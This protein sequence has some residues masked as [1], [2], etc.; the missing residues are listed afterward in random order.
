MR[1]WLTTTTVLALLAVSLAAP[2]MAHPG[3]GAL[4]ASFQAGLTGGEAVFHSG[5]QAALRA[6]PGISPEGRIAPFGGTVEVCDTQVVGTWFFAFGPDKNA[7]DLYEVVSY[8]LN[9]AEI[10]LQQTATKPIAAGPD[11]GDWWFA[12]GDP[13]L[14]VLPPGSHEIGL[15]V[16]VVGFPLSFTTTVEVD[17]AHC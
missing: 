14:G 7:A 12:A 10:D 9:G 8:T 5:G 11:K 15:D 1:R 3:A 4:Q 17:A 6:A 2:A 13:V 16:L